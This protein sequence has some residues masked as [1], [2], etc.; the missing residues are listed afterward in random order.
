VESGIGSDRQVRI[1]HERSAADTRSWQQTHSAVAQP[2]E[3]PVDPAFN[4]SFAYDQFARRT[5]APPTSRVCISPHDADD[6]H[7]GPGA[8]AVE[9]HDRDEGDV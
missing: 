7:G 9:A 4:D 3:R 2:V 1:Q 5:S 8:F 6:A